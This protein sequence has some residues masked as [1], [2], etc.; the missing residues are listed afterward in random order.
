MPAMMVLAEWRWRKTGDDV[1]L[2]LAKRWAKGTAILF[3]VGAVSGTVLS[4]EL[5]LLWPRFMEFAGADHRHSV[6]ARGVRVLHR[7]DLPRRL[8]LRLGAESRRGRTCSS[9][10]VV[11]LSGMAS[12]VFVVMVN[13]W[14]NTPRRGLVGRR[15]N[16]RGGPDRRHAQPVDVPAGAAHGARG[17]RID[18]HRRGGCARDRASSRQHAS[19]FIERRSSR[20]SRSARRRRCCS[21]SPVT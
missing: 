15:A 1:W 17:V 4:F 10:I 11:A 9:G 18:G 19:A 13:A 20:R 3:A 2:E 16:R 21:R 8:S 5:G 12:A 7:G 14:M 6:L